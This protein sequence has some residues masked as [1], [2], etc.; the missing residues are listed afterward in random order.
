MAVPMRST[1]RGIGW[2]GAVLWLAAC[3]GTIDQRGN[4]PDPERLQEIQ[5][6]V[7][8]KEE[9]ADLLG[10]PSTIATFSDDK[11]YYISTRT[12]QIAFLEPAILDQRVIVIGFDG[13]G[14]VEEILEYSS[15][16]GREIQMVNRTTP[17]A[18][19]SLSVVKQLLGNIGRFNKPK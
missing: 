15:E 12:S 10:S 11:W 3:A 5:P 4:L 17:T 7:H 9:V 14:I 8:S 2:I 6:G 13:N 18:G 1:A 16:D 19:Q